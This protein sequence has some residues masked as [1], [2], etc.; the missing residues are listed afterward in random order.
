MP[1]QTRWWRWS[2]A[3][4]DHTDTPTFG[5]SGAEENPAGRGLIPTAE[6]GITFGALSAAAVN[7]LVQN[8]QTTLPVSASRQYTNPQAPNSPSPHPTYTRSPMTSGEVQQSAIGLLT[9]WL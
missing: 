5:G 3:S 8:S 1:T 9:G 6:A 2:Y 7:L 4:D